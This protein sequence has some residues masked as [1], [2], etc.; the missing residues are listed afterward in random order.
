[1]S[2]IITIE[3]VEIHQDQNG[4]FCLND[5]HRAS[6]G[7]DKNKLSNWLQNQQTKD[8]VAE[9][10]SDAGNPLSEQNQPL[11]IIKGGSGVQGTFG[12]K[13]LVYAY[14]MW[15]SP[16]F[17]LKVI[18]TFDTLQQQLKPMTQAQ[19]AFLQAQALV[20]IEQRVNKIQDAQ[21][22]IVQATKMLDQ[23]QK[24]LE[25]SIDKK[26]NEVWDQEKNLNATQ[27]GK[28]VR[29]SA[30]EF[31]RVATY[32]GWIDPIFR[33]PAHPARGILGYKLQS[34]GKPYAI[35]RLNEDG[36]PISPVFY[37]Q[38][39]VEMVRSIVQTQTSQTW[40]QANLIRRHL[41]KV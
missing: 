30:Q 6:G 1:M 29:I 24:I 18:R 36:D 7:A 41:N 27:A 28:L 39:A 34:E 19:L 3:S 35:Q 25:S 38:A 31:N 4:R 16:A 40:S 11:V 26:L 13:E 15:I 20:E 9:I 12:V 37:N 14:A 23:R 8:L 33:H 21:T 5:L 10:I 2:N 32:L 17:H 22:K